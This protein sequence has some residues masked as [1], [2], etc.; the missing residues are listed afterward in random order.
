VRDVGN[1]TVPNRV[2]PTGAASARAIRMD[3][4]VLSRVSGNPVGTVMFYSPNGIV[5][6]PSG[7]FDVGSL[8]LTTLEHPHFSDG[9]IALGTG[10]DP[11]SA[12]GEDIDS[13]S[14]IPTVPT[15][16]IEVRQGALLR[17]RQVAAYTALVSPRIVQR[18]TI[19][20]NRRP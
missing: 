4:Q 15:S 3:G 20:S 5:I 16:F 13:G 12:Y 2:V 7:V 6:G 19:E 10:P 9:S 17:S 8:V 11:V 1:F 14:Y 18:G